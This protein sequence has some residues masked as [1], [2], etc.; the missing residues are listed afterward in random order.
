MSSMLPFFEWLFPCCFYD[1]RLKLDVATDIW[2]HQAGP[3]LDVTRYMLTSENSS[4]QQL[5]SDHEAVTRIITFG[6]SLGMARPL[7]PLSCSFARSG[8]ALSQLSYSRR[9]HHTGA[10]GQQ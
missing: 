6:T 7:A 8:Y 2:R 5:F 10:W 4:R 1:F 9:A 3:S